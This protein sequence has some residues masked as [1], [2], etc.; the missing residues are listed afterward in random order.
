MKK[1]KESVFP[2]KKKKNI[3]VFLIYF[4]FGFYFINSTFNFV[5]FPE[6]ILN[7]DKWLILIGG[8]LIVFGGINYLISGKKIKLN[9]LD[10][11]LKKI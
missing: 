11:M 9:K 5:I 8:I 6:F 4:V 2:K 10:D 7:V 1:K 3:F